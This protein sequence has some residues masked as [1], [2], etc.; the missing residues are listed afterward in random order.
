LVPADMS[1]ARAAVDPLWMVLGQQRGAGG[2]HCSGAV[3]GGLDRGHPGSGGGPPSARSPASALCHNGSQDVRQ[4]AG[5]ASASARTAGSAAGHAPVPAD[6]RHSSAEAAVRLVDERPRSPRPG[7]PRGPPRRARPTVGGRRRRVRRDVHRAERS[8]SGRVAGPAGGHAA[9]QVRPSSS[10]SGQGGDAVGDHPLV[11]RW[12]VRHRGPGDEVAVGVDAPRPGRGS[13][14]AD[15][16]ERA[17]TSSRSSGV[18]N[19][20]IGPG[21]PLLQ[22]GGLLDGGGDRVLPGVL[23]N[24]STTSP[25]L[26]TAQPPTIRP[27]HH[28]VGPALP[29]V[30]GNAFPCG[31]VPVRS[32]QP[33]W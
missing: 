31:P 14:R 33:S 15:P 10:G 3:Q 29:L 9:V 25:D 21:Q 5:E 7:R 17:R 32:C 1:T 12:D 4:F 8:R 2:G 11:R 23:R 26:L 19:R 24:R 16:Y 22:P 18:R 13:P 20:V 6:P 27:S 28:T 30:S